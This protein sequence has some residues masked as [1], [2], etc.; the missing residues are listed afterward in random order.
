[1]SGG[2]GRVKAGGGG[3]LNCRGRGGG[4]G[5]EAGALCPLDSSSLLLGGM[6]LPEVG[7]P[8]VAESSFWAWAWASCSCASRCLR[9][10]FVLNSWNDAPP[11]FNGSSSVAGSTAATGATLKYLCANATLAELLR[12]GS[13]TFEWRHVYMSHE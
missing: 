4:G 3:T 1:M 7:F 5:N 12:D 13:G 10:C 8:T 2:W 6:S 9:I 11:G